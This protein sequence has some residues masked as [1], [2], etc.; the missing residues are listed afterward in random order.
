MDRSRQWSELEGGVGGLD[1]MLRSMGAGRMEV[2]M[3]RTGPG[4]GE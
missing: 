2:E 4:S 1:R 3:G